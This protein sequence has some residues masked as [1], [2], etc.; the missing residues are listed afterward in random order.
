MGLEGVIR[1]KRTRITLPDKAQPCPLDKVN[2]QFR[3]PAPDML[4]PNG[5]AS[6]AY[7]VTGE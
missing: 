7:R 4:C 3:V 1:G 5:G 2:C 6:V